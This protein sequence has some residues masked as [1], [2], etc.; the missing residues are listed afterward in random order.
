MRMRRQR[1]L[2]KKPWKR[3]TIRSIP[4][5]ELA[6]RGRFARS[7]G[8]GHVSTLDA[9]SRLE[10]RT[11]EMLYRRDVEFARGH[12]ISVECELAEERLDQ[13]VRIRT[14]VMPRAVVRTVEQCAVPGLITDM[15]ELAE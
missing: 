2:V 12:G 9:V 6:V 13:A 1:G 7:P 14:A 5:A 4:M 15:K 10:D 11:N 3:S 8:Q